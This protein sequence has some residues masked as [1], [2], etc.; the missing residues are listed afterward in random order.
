[1]AAFFYVQM[2]RRDVFLAT[3]LHATRDVRH[4]ITPILV[5]ENHQRPVNF[6]LLKVSSIWQIQNIQF[7]MQNCKQICKKFVELFLDWICG[8]S[9]LVYFYF[10]IWNVPAASTIGTSNI[11]HIF[12]LCLFNIC[13]DIFHIF[14]LFFKPESCEDGLKGGTNAAAISKIPWQDNSFGFST[15][16]SFWVILTLWWSR[17][18]LKVWGLRVPV[19]KPVLPGTIHHICNFFSTWHIFGYNFSPHKKRVNRDKTDFP[20]KQRKPQTN[21]FATT[22]CKTHFF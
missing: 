17:K 6:K 21:W 18:W 20:V 2:I 9:M 15:L 1:M 11:C 10:M 7:Q 5:P 8:I 19:Q 12:F 16:W 4:D 3:S 13:L 14:L 22:Q